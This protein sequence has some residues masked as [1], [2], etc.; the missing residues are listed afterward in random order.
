MIYKTLYH[1]YVEINNLIRYHHFTGDYVDNMSPFERDLHI[2][3]T[4]KDIE[5]KREQ[6]EKQR[7][8]GA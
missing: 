3:I 4:I 6:G 8:R 5:S 7:A 1:H 2:G